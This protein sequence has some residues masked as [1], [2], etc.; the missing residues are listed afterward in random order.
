[1]EDGSSVETGLMG[2]EGLVGIQLWLGVERTPTRTVIQVPGGAHRMCAEDF[3]SEVMDKP[4]QLNNLISK[5]ARV[6]DHDFD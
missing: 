5:C 6:P 1:M 4:S 3:K 2:V